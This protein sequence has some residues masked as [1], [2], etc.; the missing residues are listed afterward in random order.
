MA[1]VVDETAEDFSNDGS[2][3]G[4]PNTDQQFVT[5]AVHEAEMAL[6][7]DAVA[8]AILEIKVEMDKKIEQLEAMIG[9]DQRG[10]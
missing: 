7:R 1:G 8:R 10:P 9:S 6:V 4:V 2:D 5:T 3:P